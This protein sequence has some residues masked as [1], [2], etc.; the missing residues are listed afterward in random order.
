MSDA[1][2]ER[3]ESVL[4]LLQ[5]VSEIDHAMVDPAAAVRLL[6]YVVD[7]RPRPMPAAAANERARRFADHVSRGG[8]YTISAPSI[9][10]ANGT[11][12]AP[13]R[14]SDRT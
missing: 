1:T 10:R 7:G 3:A 4:D 8:T 13:N 14:G 9:G 12:M 6:Q 11:Q 2:R 5:Q